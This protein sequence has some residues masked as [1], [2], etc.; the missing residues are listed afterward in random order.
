MR[1]LDITFVPRLGSAL[2][3]KLFYVRKLCVLSLENSSRSFDELLCSE[4]YMSAERHGSKQEN[5]EYHLICNLKFL[6]CSFNFVVFNK[7]QS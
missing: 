2:Y 4:L 5:L 7:A 1:V 6:V 3:N